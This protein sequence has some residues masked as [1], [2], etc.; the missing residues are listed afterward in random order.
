MSIIKLSKTKAEHIRNLYL[1]GGWTHL[2]LSKK[3]KCSRG[4]ITKIINDKRWRRETY[5]I[6][7]KK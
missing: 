1:Q 5:G 7:Q 4:H 3:F 6:P 2:S